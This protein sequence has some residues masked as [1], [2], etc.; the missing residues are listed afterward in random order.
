LA[1]PKGTSV[2]VPKNQVSVTFWPK[3]STDGDGEDVYHDV[4]DDDGNYMGTEPV[5]NDAGE[6]L[7]H[8]L[9]PAGFMRRAIPQPGADGRSEVFV[10]T[11]GRGNVHRNKAGE[12]VEIRP[13]SALVERGDGTSSLLT[14][15]YSIRQ[16]ELAH[17]PVNGEGSS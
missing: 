9:P 16:F 15:G 17:D 11:D 2:H 3:P 4:T 7:R 14:D 13:G 5:T 10:K 12:A 1:L 6:Q 8:H